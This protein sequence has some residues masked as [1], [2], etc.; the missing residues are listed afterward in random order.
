MIF[1]HTKKENM[2]M[3]KDYISPQVLV[4]LF[5]SEQI[6]AGSGE[7]QSKSADQAVVTPD[8]KEYTGNE[9]ASRQSLWADEDEE[10]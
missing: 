5:E 8:D 9:W 6:L 10:E 2:I 7:I 4:M 1:N 3:K